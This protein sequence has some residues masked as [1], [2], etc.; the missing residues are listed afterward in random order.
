VLA[1]TEE[2][3]LSGTQSGSVPSG[4]TLL[5]R[6]Q[7]TQAASPSIFERLVIDLLVRMGCGAI[8]GTQPPQLAKPGMVESME[9][10]TKIIWG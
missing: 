10:L 6:V 4:D 5:W 9:Q 8:D 2:G 3:R 1:I 7:Q